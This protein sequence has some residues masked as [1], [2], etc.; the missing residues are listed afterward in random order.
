MTFFLTICAAVVPPLFL[1]AF[2]LTYFRHRL[3]LRLGLSSVMGGVI[4]APLALGFSIML[5]NLGFPSTGVAGVVA[6]A[7]IGAAIPEKWPSS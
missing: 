3:G 5:S 1:I 7:W 2:F 6:K 4:S